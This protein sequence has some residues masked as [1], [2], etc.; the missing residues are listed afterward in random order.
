MV[1]LLTI[2]GKSYCVQHIGE[3]KGYKAYGENQFDNNIARDHQTNK[4]N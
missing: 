3:I 1:Y 2:E 4:N